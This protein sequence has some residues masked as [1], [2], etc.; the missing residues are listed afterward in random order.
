MATYPQM[1]RKYLLRLEGSTF[2][3]TDRYLGAAAKNTLNKMQD[4]GLVEVAC[5]NGCAAGCDCPD[6]E[7]AWQITDAGLGRI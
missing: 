6:E 5:I 7:K 2:A 3:L 1:R 4:E